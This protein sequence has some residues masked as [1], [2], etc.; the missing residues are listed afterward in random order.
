MISVLSFSFSR[1]VAGRILRKPFPVETF[2]PDY[3]G[4]RG[5][6]PV[7]SLEQQAQEFEDFKR[8]FNAAQGK[9]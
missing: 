2:I 4:M 1:T 3:L 5:K 9:P 6:R 7:K 8:R